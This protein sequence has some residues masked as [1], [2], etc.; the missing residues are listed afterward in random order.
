MLGAGE[1][2][3]LRR[4]SR[5]LFD[6]TWISS[7]ILTPWGI[8]IGIRRDTCLQD[9]YKEIRCVQIAITQMNDSKLFSVRKI[10]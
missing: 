1:Y 4:Y 8:Q 9:S 3:W 6:G 7:G 10:S 2:M 5:V